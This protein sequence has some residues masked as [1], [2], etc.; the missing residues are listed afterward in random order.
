MLS[1]RIH[2]AFTPFPKLVLSHVTPERTIPDSLVTL[3]YLLFTSSR[4]IT[5]MSKL[6]MPRMIRHPVFSVDSGFLRNDGILDIYRRS[7]N[8]QVVVVMDYE[9]NY[10]A[11]NNR[12]IWKWTEFLNQ[13][14][15]AASRD[16]C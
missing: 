8:C 3:L 15:V 2:T 14:T 1:L 7:N 13:E 5:N 16:Q 11:G 9:K 4:I 10:A 12:N 6:V